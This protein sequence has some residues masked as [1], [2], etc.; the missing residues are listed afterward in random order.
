MYYDDFVDPVTTITQ[1]TVHT[2]PTVNIGGYSGLLMH[3][4][5]SQIPIGTVFSLQVS[6]KPTAPSGDADWA[7]IQSGAFS[8]TSKSVI[9]E[10]SPA[11]KWVRY[12]ITA[13]IGQ[14]I[15]GFVGNISARGF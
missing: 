3:L 9:S 15:T 11:G 1:N 14:D 6:G 4:Q 12:Q 2:S 10:I 8:D 7:T 5:A 13:G